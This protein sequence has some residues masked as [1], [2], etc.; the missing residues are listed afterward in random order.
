[1]TSPHYNSKG[2]L[3]NSGNKFLIAPLCLQRYNAHERFNRNSK[4]KTRGS[5]IRLA[6][7]DHIW[8]KLNLL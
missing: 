8:E 5:A 3:I 2:I 6:T 7:H 4:R 1:M